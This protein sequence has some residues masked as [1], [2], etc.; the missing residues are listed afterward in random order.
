MRFIIFASI[1]LRLSIAVNPDDS[2][3]SA[4]I[5]T[6]KT[7][8]VSAVDGVETRLAEC[9][10]KKPWIGRKTGRA[11]FLAAGLGCVKLALNELGPGFL[12]APIPSIWEIM[13]KPRLLAAWFVLL[14]AITFTESQLMNMMFKPDPTTQGAFLRESVYHGIMKGSAHYRFGAP[15]SGF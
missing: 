14:E 11:L 12:S 1:L 3:P 6:V 9:K 13:D 15:F 7:D 4:N 8:S 10:A 5:E 2:L